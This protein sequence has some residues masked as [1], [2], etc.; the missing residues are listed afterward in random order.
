MAK[1]NPVPKEN[2]A[3][4]WRRVGPLLEEIKKR[5]MQAAQKPDEPH[6][7]EATRRENEDTP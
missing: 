1:N 2:Y 5:E 3:E 6:I 7:V 4:Y